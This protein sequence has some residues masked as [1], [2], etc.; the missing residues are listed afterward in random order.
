MCCTLQCSI[1]DEQRHTWKESEVMPSK[2]VPEKCAF[3]VNLKNN[4]MSV[5]NNQWTL[6]VFRMTKKFVETPSEIC[7]PAFIFL[8][9]RTQVV[10]SENN[11]EIMM[12]ID[13][14]KVNVVKKV[15]LK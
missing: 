6:D 3:R 2:C 10:I 9:L 14:C 4:L 8:P 11:K 13:E 12:K 1:L 15:E 7:S 5:Q